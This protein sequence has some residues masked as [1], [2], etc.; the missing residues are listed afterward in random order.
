MLDYSHQSLHAEVQS[1]IIEW[2]AVV[3]HCVLDYKRQTLQARYDCQPLQACSAA[4]ADI[5]L[6]TMAECSEMC[7]SASACY[8][9]QQEHSLR[10][11]QSLLQ[12]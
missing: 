12:T 8:A 7:G 2:A 10:R 9:V 11:L 1:L 3:N 5:A 4:E 6:P